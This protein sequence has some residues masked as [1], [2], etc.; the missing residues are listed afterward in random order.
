[1]LFIQISSWTSS[2]ILFALSGIHF[3][4]VVKGKIGTNNRVIPEIQ[5]KPA[6][7]PGRFATAIVGILL[8]LAALFPIGLQVSFGIFRYVFQYGTYFLSATFLLRAIGDF[9]LLG[10]FKKIRDTKFAKNDTA[11]YSP[12]CLLLSVLLFVSTL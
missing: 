10:F 8:L 11:Y 4:W 3:Y 5:G 9:R 12:L 1:M 7:Q 2:L 6:F